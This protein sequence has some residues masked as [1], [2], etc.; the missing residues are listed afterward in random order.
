M[1]RVRAWL[2]HLYTA[3]GVVFALL[4]TIES[5]V[6]RVF[7]WLTIAVLI[8]ATDGPLARRFDVKRV[9]PHISGRSIDDIVDYL[10]FTFVPLLLVVR[11]EWVPSIWFV[12]PALMASL[13]GFANSGAKDESGGFFLGFPSYWNIA[14]F[15]FGI[16]AARGGE[17]INAI[18]ILALAVLTVMPVG[19][20][21]PNLAPRRWK[22]L[23]LGGAVVWLAMLMA[24]LPRY[25]D[26][27]LWLVALSLVYPLFYTVVSFV[28]Y[29]RRLAAL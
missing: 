22:A 11:M 28:E 23:I 13:L 4:A 5:D 29:R 20:I 24:M 14:A 3:S 19:F 27:P 9:L 1:S 17:M 25:P 26:P 16:I 12:V 10:T 7:V 6:K 15:Y 2:V 18:L 8:D 21:Y